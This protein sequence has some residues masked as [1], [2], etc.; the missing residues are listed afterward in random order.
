MAKLDFVLSLVILVIVFFLLKNN[1]GHIHAISK[2]IKALKQMFERLSE[3]LDKMETPTLTVAAPELP[4]NS[5]I[6]S[7]Q[8][9]SAV[10]DKINLAQ[11][12]SSL[13]P[14]ETLLENNVAEKLESELWTTEQ[15]AAERQA[16]EEREQERLLA[17][18]LQEEFLEQQ[19]QAEEKQAAAKLAHETKV[20][21]QTPEAPNWATA[22]LQKKS[23]PPST[24]IK[25]RISV[26]APELIRHVM[27]FL[28]GGNIWAA[29]GVVMLLLGFA[30]LLSYM[31]E[32]DILTI[33]MR[34]SMAA[35]VGLVMVGVGVKI[36]TL[37]PTFAVITQ[38]G[39][40]GV[41]YLSIF[42]AAKLTTLIGA[43]AALILMTFL[44]VSAVALAILQNA[45]LL[46]LFGFLGG[47]AAPILLSDQSGNYVALFSYYGLLGLGLL[48]LSWFRNWIW[49]FT[50]A[51]ATTFVIMG[52]WIFQSYEAYLHFNSVQPFLIGFGLIFTSITLLSQSRGRLSF[53]H[54]P[55]ANLALG[56]PFA[57]ICLQ[58]AL[59]KDLPHGLAWS[60]GI[61]GA[62]YLVFSGL[63]WRFLAHD[64]SE[65]KK[66][67][68]LFLACGFLSLNMILPLESS[69]QMTASFWALEGG[70]IFLFATMTRS[71]PL[72][73]AALGLQFFGLFFLFDSSV[74][75]EDN[76]LL[77]TTAIMGIAAIA[78]AV[79]Q[80]GQENS[81]SSEKLG[82]IE[83]AL[84]SLSLPFILA[85]YGVLVWFFGLA[86]DCVAFLPQPLFTFLLGTSVSSFLIYL[87]GRASD[88]R[89]LQKIGYLPLLAAAYCL[90]SSLFPVWNYLPFDN[91][92][93][94]NFLK[95]SGSWAW[96]AFILLQGAVLYCEQT[97]EQPKFH[98]FRVGA[99]VLILVAMT[100]ST[101]RAMAQHLYLAPSW[102]WLAG[103]LPSLLYM[104]AVR[105]GAKR[106]SSQRHIEV[107]CGG[108]P[109][110]LSAVLAWW[111][112][113]T[114]AEPGDPAPL[115]FYLPIVNPLEL[116]QAFCIAAFALWQITLQDIKTVKAKLSFQ[117]LMLALDVMLFIWLHSILFRSNYF[118]AGTPIELIKN[119]PSF[120][121]SV[122]ILWSIW[123]V[124]H[125][126][127]GAKK[128]V[129]LIW[130]IG[131]SL[132]GAVAVK[133]FLIDIADKETIVRIISFLVTGMVFLFVGWQ[134]PL[135]PSMKQKKKGAD[136]T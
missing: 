47:Y 60:A 121:T 46:A 85:P 49:L 116:L 96:L 40:I 119:T 37:R 53:S 112:I 52:G 87:I 128:G 1:N 34:I 48:G 63:V 65:G 93:S 18:R 109:T 38:G 41:L 70:L 134:A 45:Q 20:E 57:L 64:S 43:P 6:A 59:V 111:F 17:V 32:K 54:A 102:I 5:V 97:E 131:A 73:I 115:P 86:H 35:L 4:E 71:A 8:S 61:M 31:A 127:V 99:F 76:R 24:G 104:G 122:T 62:T 3:K 126:V 84:R 15:L 124:S 11:D 78:S 136:G 2:E 94:F 100:T 98:A 19:R 36:R 9:S 95:G 120:Q 30:Y 80:K 33:E 56:T 72:K 130:L 89:F 42:G 58:I 125:M 10:D 105:W 66:L 69:S 117:N 118:L 91:L 77:L 25:E 16:I 106:L 13:P 26:E 135:P 92:L 129:R 28:R 90:I 82:M 123:G 132:L 22:L 75:Q 23:A 50:I 21:E 51:A 114:L 44:I 88:M 133:L 81:R 101:G 55:D 27:E 103:I 67:A 113:T 83:K 12:I 7:P 110:I 74:S 39:G 79:M 107:L 68:G 108:A 14:V 29:G